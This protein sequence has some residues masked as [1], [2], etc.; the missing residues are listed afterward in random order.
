MRLMFKGL[1]RT[2]KIYHII[3]FVL[4]LVCIACEREEPVKREIPFT[5]YLPAETMVRH[6]SPRRVMGDPGQTERFALPN[7]IYLFVFW[8]QE[9]EW[10]IMDQEE[11]RLQNNDWK[12][13]RYT[14]P[15]MS[16]G[17]SIYSVTKRMNIMLVGNNVQGRTYAIA[18]PVPLTF[19]KSLGS[20]VTLDD[21]LDLKIDVSS[22]EI[23]DNLHN[24][25]TTPYNY[26]VGG[27]YYG[28]FDNSVNYVVNLD[29]MLYHIASKVDIKW[30]VAED[31]RINADPSQAVRLTYMEARRLFNGWAYCFMPLRNTLPELPSSGYD[32]P[33]IV[34]P[35]DEGL[36]WE[37]RAYFYTIPYTVEGDP[38]Y[39]PLQMKMGTNGTKETA[40]YELTLKQKTDTSD[41]FVPWIRG[42]FNFNQPLDTKTA[43]KTVD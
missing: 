3:L 2:K 17:D 6:Q 30:S 37:G 9:G 7:Y 23:Q 43:V 19:S 12:A 24:I 13:T 29:L 32:I 39:F 41:V 40:G 1:M 15:L 18:S 31:K 22:Q 35:G 25:Y 8:K 27:Q 34:S 26:E 5:I 33:D 14:G 28:A 11:W 42:V 36:W 20:I 10:R 38:N 16:E 4:M 21:V